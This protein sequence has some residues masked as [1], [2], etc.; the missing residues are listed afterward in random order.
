MA[1][2]NLVENNVQNRVSGTIDQ[3]Q[4]LLDLLVH[5]DWHTGNKHEDGWYQY[6]TVISLVQDHEG[7]IL[8][9]FTIFPLIFGNED[10]QKLLL[11]FAFIQR[12]S[13]SFE[14]FRNLSIDRLT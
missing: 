2:V 9:G 6:I 3:L 1:W 12:P 5:D 11:H 13:A 10:L 4:A 14:F 7:I 8:R